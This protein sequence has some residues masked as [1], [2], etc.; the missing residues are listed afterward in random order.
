MSIHHVLEGPAGA[1]VLV[2]PSSLGTSTALWE[3]NLPHWPGLRLL[4]YDQRGHESVDELGRDFLDLIDA[5][6]LERVSVCGLSLGGATAMWVASYAPERVDRLVL[7]CTSATFGDPEPWLERAA[8]VREQGLEPLAGAILANWF[9]PSFADEQPEAFARFR[10]LLI[11][12]PREPYARSCE[13]LARWDF[14]DRLADIDATTLVIAA[15][16]D[17]ST[18]PEHGELLA[19]GIPGAR[20]VVLSDAAHLANVEQADAFSSLV[21]EHLASVEVA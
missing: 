17:P 16:R 19:R 21:A 6:A 11:G 20:L 8:F 15:A 9:T 14:R 2:L 13:A 12:T 4:R 5:L 3:A 7:A 1:P 10:R 18:P